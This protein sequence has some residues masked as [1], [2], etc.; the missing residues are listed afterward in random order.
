VK[1]VAKY[2]LLFSP[3]SAS[4][5]PLP[6][7]KPYSYSAKKRVVS[8]RKNSILQKTAKNCKKLRAF[9]RLYKPAQN[10]AKTS[11]FPAFQRNTRDFS[12]IP[13]QNQ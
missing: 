13:P 8:R 3:K 2:L 5:E 12:V 1:S 11:P 10:H 9:A 7:K 6:T 4:G